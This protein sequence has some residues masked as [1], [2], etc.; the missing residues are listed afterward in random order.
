V[1]DVPFPCAFDPEAKRYDPQRPVG[2]DNV[3]ARWKRRGPHC[4]EF[5]DIMQRGRGLRRAL[6]GAA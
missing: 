5:V 1:L 4:G 6:A 3:L 2:W